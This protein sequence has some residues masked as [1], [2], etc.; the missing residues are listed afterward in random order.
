MQLR[1]PPLIVLLL[2]GAL[3]WW[4]AHAAPVVGVEIP[5]RV[6]IVIAFVVLGFAVA[7]AGVIQFRRASTTVNPLTPQESSSLVVTG[8]YAY[9]R[10]PMYLGMVLVLTGWAVCLA[11]PLALLGVIAFVIYED[12]FQIVPEERALRGTFGSQFD[13][14]VRRVRRWI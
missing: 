2:A 9:T 5:G 10:N 1:I 3:M 8:I 4:L 14:Y 7:V 13:D 11:N 12:R 6:A